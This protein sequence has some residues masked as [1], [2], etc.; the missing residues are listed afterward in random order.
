MKRMK[1]HVALFPSWLRDP[2]S[3]SV[4]KSESGQIVVVS[5]EGVYLKTSFLFLK[6]RIHFVQVSHRHPL[7]LLKSLVH[8]NG[9]VKDGIQAMASFLEKS[10][11]FT[12]NGHSPPTQS[13]P[14]CTDRPLTDFIETDS[15]T[16]TQHEPY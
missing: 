10:D 3:K 5:F 14:H 11:A 7:Y 8:D 6:K 16:F 1:G 9:L 13:P 12:K 2:T 15:Q 4:D